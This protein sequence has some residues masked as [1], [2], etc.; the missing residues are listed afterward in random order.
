MPPEPPAEKPV[1]DRVG[2]LG[3]R[4]PAAPEQHMPPPRRRRLGQPARGDRERLPQVRLE[5]R[6]ARAVRSWPCGTPRSTGRTPPPG[7]THSPGCSTRLRCETRRRAGIP[8]GPPTRGSRPGS[9]R[10]R[11]LRVRGRTSVRAIPGSAARASA[12]KDVESVRSRPEQSCASL[13]HPVPGG[14]PGSG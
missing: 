2:L 1:N 3:K 14:E 8:A 11:T 5:I 10:H 13:T 7:S 6:I 12:G 4:Q 9:S